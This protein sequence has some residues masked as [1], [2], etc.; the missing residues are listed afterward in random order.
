MRN[1]FRLMWNKGWKVLLIV[2]LLWL[3]LLL[4]NFIFPNIFSFS[5]KKNFLMNKPQNQE[6]YNIVEEKTPFREKIY[7]IFFNSFNFNLKS[8]EE[9]NNKIKERENKI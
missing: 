6:N 4:L 7:N 2:V 9:I 5:N 3:A 8:K 1:F